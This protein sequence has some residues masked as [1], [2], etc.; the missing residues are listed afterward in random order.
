MS[1]RQTSTRMVLTKSV[2]DR[3]I[4]AT[5]S[6]GTILESHHAAVWVVD[7]DP[8]ESRQAMFDSLDEAVVWAETVLKE[9]V[10][11]ASC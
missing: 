4:V 6:L 9:L 7:D 5:V 1:W 3:M 2:G 10:Q 8:V 11:E